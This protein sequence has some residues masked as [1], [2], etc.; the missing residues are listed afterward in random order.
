MRKVVITGLGVVSPLG[1]DEAVVWQR[2]VTGQ[3]GIRR[4]RQ[5]DV[6]PYPSQIA[7]EVVEFNTVAGPAWHSGP[8]KTGRQ[9]SRLPSNHT[10]SMES[11][12]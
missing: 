12:R 11:S 9:W 10:Q 1:C 2:L 4:V 8:W 5:F 7:G 6:A 3:S